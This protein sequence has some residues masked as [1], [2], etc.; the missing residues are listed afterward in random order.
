MK[1]MILAAGLGTRLRPLTLERAKPAVPL[2]G[3]PLVRRLMRKLQTLGVSDFRLNLHHLPDTIETLFEDAS[4]NNFQVSFSFEEEILGTAGGL[5]ANEAFFGNE[6]FIMA[7]G[8]IVLDLP[9]E[10]ALIYHRKT[11]ALATLVLHPQDPPFRHTPVR[12]DEDGLVVN[13]KDA[14][15]GARA[16]PDAYVFT[17]VHII[18]PEIFHYIP[19]KKFHEINAQVYPA[20][21]RDGRRVC[22]F[23]VLHGYWNDL[24]TPFRYIEAQRDL[25]VLS[26]DK[27]P[28]L[29]STAASVDSQAVIGPFVTVDSGCRLEA[30]SHSENAILWEG[31]TVAR[32]ARLSN[33]IIGKNVRVTGSCSDKVVTRYGE[34]PI[35]RY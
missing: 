22:G 1:A 4:Q 16:L 12:L 11:G 9:L 21:L 26:R 20:A 18:E 27:H 10:Q 29:L 30:G 15:L 19:P 17:G 5:K 7:N 13:F 34:V 33:C 3:E 35:A 23:P 8:D 32:N 25:F 31:V 24:G 6:T 28:Q 2:L 14:V